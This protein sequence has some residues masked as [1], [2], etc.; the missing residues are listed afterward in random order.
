[1][2]TV[3]HLIPSCYT[4]TRSVRFWGKDYMVTPAVVYEHLGDGKKLVAIQ[5]L[6]TRPDYYLIRVDS[7][8]DFDSCEW[9]DETLEEIQNAID[10]QFGEQERVREM[11]QE[12]RGVE[13]VDLADAPD[14]MGWPVASWDSGFSWSC[15]CEDL[16]KGGGK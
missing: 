2:S 3:K 13:Y 12:E 4:K 6:N 11:L 7:S 5:P 16:S 14:E 10:E 8:A 9:Y 15:V 1:M